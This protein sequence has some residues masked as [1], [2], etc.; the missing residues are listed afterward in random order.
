M[1]WNIS[2]TRSG[3][4]TNDGSFRISAEQNC[5]PWQVILLSIRFSATVCTYRLSIHSSASISG[6]KI[7]SN[8]GAS[9]KADMNACGTVLKSL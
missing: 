7:S 6:K 4:I 1:K 3:S 9:R 5:P 2:F 8:E